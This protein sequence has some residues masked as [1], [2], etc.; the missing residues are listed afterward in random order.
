M[1]QLNCNRVR[2]TIHV[3]FDRAWVLLVA[4]FLGVIGA[5]AIVRRELPMSMRSGVGHHDVSPRRGR[6]AVIGGA[7]LLA[8]AVALI[9]W[10]IL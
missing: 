2:Q 1:P 3:S 10:M 5:R 6:D 7:S 8:V 4:A 9:V